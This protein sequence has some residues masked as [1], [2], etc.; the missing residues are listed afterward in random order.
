MR[1]VQWCAVWLV[2]LL[3]LVSCKTVS[4]QQRQTPESMV[5]MTPIV[6]STPAPDPIRYMVKGLSDRELIGQMVMV[7]FDGAQSPSGDVVRLMV[8]YKV[9]S[10]ILFGWNIETF[11]QTQALVERIVE[12]N[13]LPE[14]PMLI[15]TDVEGGLVTRFHWSPS[16]KSAYLLGKSGDTDL[17]YE[18]FKRIGEGLRG[19]GITVDLAPVMDI[20]KTMA[21]TFL[22]ED[23][24]MFSSDAD[25]TGELVSAAVMGLHDGGVL[26]FGKHFPGHGN[27]SVDSHDALPVLY[28]ARDRWE[29]YERLP[30]QS[31]IDVG[32]DGMLVGHMSYPN[33]DDTITS[34]SSVVITD[35]LRD[36]MGFSGIIMSDD[37]RMS[38]ISNYVGTGEAAVRFVEAGGD[39]VLI[40]R[41]INKQ[42]A[43]LDALYEALQNGRITRD[44]CEQSVYRILLAKQTIA[45]ME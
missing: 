28:T 4:M 12:Y 43:V 16:T 14:L 33:F 1:K 32:L 23:R 13:P 21:G 24:R 30:F 9:G 17:A 45:D 36:D 38:A 42:E 2:S 3:M 6:T 11:A 40:G 29:Q 18:Q 25:L 10:I 41:Y 44:R 27:T 35:I 34:I 5:T 19:C 26:S 31:A 37:M 7:G 39:L 15:A 22:N 8:D 20:A